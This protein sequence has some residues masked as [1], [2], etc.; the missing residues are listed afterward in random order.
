MDVAQLHGGPS[1]TVTNDQTSLVTLQGS[2]ADVNTILAAGVTYLGQLN[3]NGN[4]I[5]TVTADD[6]GNWPAPAQTTTASL[7]VAVAA[8]ND[9][10]AI[11]APSTAT[12]D[13]DTELPLSGF[14]LVDVDSAATPITVTLTVSGRND[15]QFPNGVLTIKPVTGGVDPSSAQVTG[16]ATSLVTITAPVAQIAATLSNVNGWAYMPPGNFAGNTASPKYEI[17]TITAGDGGAS[18]VTSPSGTTDTR[19][20]TLFVNEVNDPPLVTVPAGPASVLEDQVLN[21]RS[22]GDIEITDADAG[23]AVISVQLSVGRGTINLNPAVPGAPTIV[24]NGTS[25]VNL[26]G[27][28][29]AINALLRFVRELPGNPKHERPGRLDDLG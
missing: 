9:P 10:P 5:V 21:I 4:D 1:V 12:A 19:Q 25:Q 16:N 13:E 20:V 29:V 7:T 3:L 18:G 27:T 23:N 17:L 11:T 14:N 15:G 2:L 6:L 8:V 22:L 24:G 28:L 26:S